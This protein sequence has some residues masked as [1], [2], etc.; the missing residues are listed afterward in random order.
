MYVRHSYTRIAFVIGLIRLFLE[1]SYTIDGLVG[2]YSS[3]YGLVNIGKSLFSINARQPFLKSLSAL[4]CFGVKVISGFNSKFIF[5]MLS[6]D[7]VTAAF[8]A[9]HI[10]SRL[11]LDFK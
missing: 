8:V 1:R 11:T 5:Y 10:A 9:R 4:L 2:K 3:W 6:N 7:E